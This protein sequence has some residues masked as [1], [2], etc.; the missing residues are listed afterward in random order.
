MIQIRDFRDVEPQP[1][2]NGV[3][4]RVVIGPDEGAP[5]FTMR[6]FEVQPGYASPHHSH[7]WEHEIFVLA[8]QGMLRTDQGDV[9]VQHGS[10]I[11]VPG[12]EMHQLRNT[13]QEVL[14]FICL[15]PQEWL[16]EVTRP[17]T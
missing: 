2:L 14:R 3:T 13:G 17:T 6:V 4:M 15:I 10:T 5:H 11:F 16:G 7:W 12:G 9:P 1:A 8:G